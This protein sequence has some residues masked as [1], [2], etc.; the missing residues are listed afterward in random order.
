MKNKGI[1]VKK[2]GS[3]IELIALHEGRDLSFL[4]PQ[5]CAFS[6]HVCTLTQGK[7]FFETQ[8]FLRKEGLT[9]PTLAE[10]ASIIYAAHQNPE[11]KYSQAVINLIED[12]FIWVNNGILA[13]PKKG[14]YVIDHPESRWSAHFE[15]SGLV[16]RL[17]A[18]DKSIRFTPFGYESF[19]IPAK[20]LSKNKLLIAL[21]GKEGAEKLA[22]VASKYPEDHPHNSVPCPDVECNAYG[23]PYSGFIGLCSRDYLSIHDEEGFECYGFS[24][25]LK[26]KKSE[27]KNDNTR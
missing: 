2:T 8:K 3:E 6:S 4:V 21:A 18:G 13:V 11:N 25:A 5:S 19:E 22:E 15:E 20:D 27:T 23:E 17:K 26:D 16:K 12:E 7:N 24:F 1:R 9:C 14:V 10:V